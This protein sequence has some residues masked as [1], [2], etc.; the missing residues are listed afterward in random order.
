M[1]GFLSL[2]W[3]LFWYLLCIPFLLLGAWK[4]RKLFQAHP[5]K[6]LTVAISGAFI[7]VISSLKLPSISGSSSHPTGTGLST[8]LSGP[9]ITCVL[10]TIVLVFQALI[11]AH[12]GITTLGANVFS[13]GIVGPFVAYGTFLLMQKAR[14][15]PIATIFVVSFVADLATYITTSIQLAMAYPSNGSILTSFATFLGIFAITQIPLAIFEAILIVLFFDYL[16][17]FRPELSRPD[18]MIKKGSKVGWASRMIVALVVA[19]SIIAVPYL[20]I[21]GH[22]FTGADDQSGQAIQDIDPNY[23]PWFENL[24]IAPEGME[25]WLFALQAAIGISI[26]LAI[27]LFTR[28]RRRRHDHDH[29]GMDDL[30]YQSPMREWPP[31]GKFFLALALLI[32][33]LVSSTYLIPLIVLSMGLALL[34]YSTRM[35]LPHMVA[36]ALLNGLAVIAVGCIIIALLTKGGGYLTFPIFGFDLIIYRDGLNLATMVFLRAVAGMVV[37][38]W[39]ISSTPIPHLAVALRQLHLPHEVGEMTILVYRYSF[40]LLEQ[41]DVMYTAAA[42]RLGFR[43]MSNRLKTSSRLAVGLF[44]RSMGM[45][46][47]SQI[48]LQCRNF[49]GDFPTFRPPRKMGMVWTLVPILVGGLLLLLNMVLSNFAKMMW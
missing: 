42:C 19:A 2:W 8:M 6:K 33:S 27:I 34:L 9:A 17:N 18:L 5:E 4:L 32:V 35:K 16:S 49:K 28:R 30:A 39:F 25:G 10:S 45:A 12:G 47:R 20:L 29:M 3:C 36:L 38:L 14:V 31:L 22:V 46:E 43:G 40:L 15:H 23:K 21:Q 7:F 26:I 1:E 37:M 13:M 24:F 44:S 11:L 48:A 41:L